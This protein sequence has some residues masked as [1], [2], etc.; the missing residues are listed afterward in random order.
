M[1]LLILQ[2]HSSTFAY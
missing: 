1:Q 2:F